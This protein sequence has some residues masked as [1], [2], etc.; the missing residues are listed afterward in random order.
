MLS[1]RA[2]S[3]VLSSSVYFELSGFCRTNSPELASH[4]QCPEGESL[5]TFQ[6][7]S[8]QEEDGRWPADVLEA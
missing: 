2:A 5:I 1:G 4:I 7:E 8:E 3:P 6:V